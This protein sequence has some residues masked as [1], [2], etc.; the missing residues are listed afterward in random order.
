MRLSCPLG[1]AGSPRRGSPVR[2][3]GFGGWRVLP[4]GPG[5]AIAK[6]RRTWWQASDGHPGETKREREWKHSPSLCASS[7]A[8]QPAT[9]RSVALWLCVPGS[10]RV[11]PFGGSSPYSVTRSIHHDRDFG[12]RDFSGIVSPDNPRAC[13]HP[14]PMI[15]L[16]SHI[17]RACCGQRVPPAPHR[18]LPELGGRGRDAHQDREEPAWE[19]TG[20]GEAIA[21]L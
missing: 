14:L 21:Q 7:S 6:A 19:S 1:A 8:A 9:L 12:N 2:R 3:A 5:R 11:C 10:L 18:R 15:Q 16:A 17:E 13:P 4:R 20:G